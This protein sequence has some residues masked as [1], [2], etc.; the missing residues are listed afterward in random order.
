MV[1]SVTSNITLPS[2]CS[3]NIVLEPSCLISMS[4]AV[5]IPID[6]LSLIDMFPAKKAS[7]PALI[8]R[9][10]AVISEPPSLPLNIK[11]LSCCPTAKTTSPLAFVIFNLLPPCELKF[12]SLPAASNVI[13]PTESTKKSPVAIFISPI[14]PLWKICISLSAPN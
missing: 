5:P 1:A 10:S 6:L 12:Q 7:P 4:F 2:P 14:A 9:V 8:S 3:L 11:S 13:S